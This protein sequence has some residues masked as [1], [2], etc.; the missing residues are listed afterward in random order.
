MI[1]IFVIFAIYLGI[2]FILTPENADGMLAGYNTLSDERKAKY[3]ITKVVHFQNKA[4]RLL[5]LCTLL[6]GGLALYLEYTF[7][8]LFT[9]LYLPF[10]VLIGAGIYSRV[11]FSTDPFRWYDWLIYAAIL[12]FLVF[13]TYQLPFGEMNI[14][15]FTE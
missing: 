14:S 3:D 7:L 8:Y 11:K 10:I 15:D 13:I 4:L 6:L 12:I 5:A 1:P 9:L 2:S